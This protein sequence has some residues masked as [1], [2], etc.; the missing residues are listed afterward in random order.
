M[1]ELSGLDLSVYILVFEFS[2]LYFNAQ[3]L[4]DVLVFR[5]DIFVFER[6]VLYF[7]V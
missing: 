1:F 2:V 4:Y 6:N 7:C 5:F 3:A